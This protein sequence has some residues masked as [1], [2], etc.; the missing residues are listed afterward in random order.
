M[1]CIYFLANKWHLN[2]RMLIIFFIFNY[3]NK[4]LLDFNDKKISIYVKTPEKH[5]N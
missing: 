5:C 4:W 2:L 3:K 1:V